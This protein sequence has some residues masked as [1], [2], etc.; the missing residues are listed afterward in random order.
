MKHLDDAIEKLT[1]LRILAVK[2]NLNDMERGLYEVEQTLFKAYDEVKP[3][4]TDFKAMRKAK[5]LT[6]RDVEARTGISNA[7]LCQ[8]ESGKIVKPSYHTVRTLND[9]YNSIPDISG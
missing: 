7:Y 9:L 3:V 8:L 1:R 4:R 6:L 5:N 2:M